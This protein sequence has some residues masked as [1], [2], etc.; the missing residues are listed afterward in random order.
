MEAQPYD[1]NDHAAPEGN[2][3]GLPEVPS[4]HAAEQPL[5]DPLPELPPPNQADMEIHHHTHHPAD[6]GHGKRT[7]KGYFWEFVMLFLA[8]FLGFFA[9]YELE[10]KIEREREK[11]YIISMVKDLY[12]D[13]VNFSRFI[14]DGRETM[15]MIDSVLTLLNGPDP[16]SHARILYLMARKITHTISNYEL[17]DRTYSALRYSGNLRLFRDHEVAD[18]ITSYYADIPT[19][20]TQQHYIFNLL[21]HYIRDV[22]EVFEPTV[23]HEIYKTAGLT[24]TDTS[25]A[26][27]FRYLLRPP[28]TGVSLNT[29]PESIRKL[30]STLHY[31]YARILSTNSNVRNQQKGA[32]T[33]MAFL[34]ARYGLEKE[35]KVPDQP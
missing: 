33:L 5:T 11:R 9:H 35:M 10:H 31:L 6:P 14:R 2:A 7:W 16:N 3:P 4:D 26:S 29:D 28:A 34:I 13:T 30:S 1:K 27:S 32:A 18:N 19:L 21:L 20:Q 8:V 22:N 25:D 23:F 15:G 17:V 24:V 12:M